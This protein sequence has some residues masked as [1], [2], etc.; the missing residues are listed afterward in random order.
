MAQVCAVSLIAAACLMNAISAEAAVRE[1]PKFIP[2]KTDAVP[3]GTRVDVLADKLTYDGRSKIATATGTVRL[4]YGPYVLTASRVVYDMRRKKFSAN[5]SIVLR[6]PNGNVLQASYAE[7]DEKFAEGFAEHVKAL[8]TNNV[9]ITAKYARR[10]ENGVTVYENASYTACKTCVDEGGTPLW[11]IVA[12]EARHD[13]QERTIYY[14]NAKLE[15]GGVPVLW[16]PYLAYP[17]PSVTRRTGFLLP[18]FHGGDYGIGVTTPYFWAL[19]RDKD[20]T[21]SPMWTTTQGPLADVEYRQ[22]FSKGKLSVRGYG[23]YELD[24]GETGGDGD[25]PWR[26]AVRTRGDFK[27]S[28]HW[29][30]GW[31]GTLLSDRTFL[32]DYDLDGR[33]MIT[34]SVQA[35][36]LED[37]NYAKA[38]ILNFRSALEN[39]SQDALPYA[40]PYVTA[41][42]VFDQPILGGDLSFD[43]SAY[44]LH[45]E[46][47]VFDPSRGLDL[48]TDQ[49]HVTAVLDWR[50]QMITGLGM[51]LTPFTQ[52]RSDF[53]VSRNVPGATSEDAD[54]DLLP[55]AG[56]DVRWPFIADHGAAQGILTPVFQ[57]IAAPS[58]PRDD[59]QANEDA[60]T[61]NFDSTSLF[62][63]DRFTGYDRYEGGMRANAGLSYTLLGENGGFIR[64]S[65]GE[66]FHI[67]GE[68]SFAAGSGLD[69]TSS[70]LVGAVALQLNENVTLGYQARLEEDLSRLNVQEASLGL[71]LDDISGSLSYADI[72]AASGYGRPTREQQIWG[73]AKYMMGEA[74]NL[75][76]S[77]RYDIEGSRFMEKTIGIGFDC[78]CMNAS[79]AYSETL[80][81]RGEVDHRIALS[82]ELRTIGEVDGGFKY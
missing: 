44:S 81:E 43:F 67:A 19:S 9:T 72:A 42:Y 78:D 82:V 56:F 5:G 71:T 14:K 27:L 47:A 50:R 68:N 37:R 35:T 80:E 57:L 65:F 38:Q 48:G 34:S 52:L 22:A 11:Q 7:L 74:W 25:E 18:N 13:L 39:E 30:L 53:N 24:P 45:R 41:N 54:G 23:I 79:V 58:E 51:Q 40:V 17:D 31:D 32:N 10:Y 66:S 21:F 49:S 1:D 12:G 63:S 75:F 2:P 60:I 61:L 62:L 26:G 3:A 46:E 29:N 15:V 77:F 16:T 36:G 69:G 8:L 33:D 64:T 59:D 4:T 28:R 55:S 6:E 20:I 76:G 70:D 73:N